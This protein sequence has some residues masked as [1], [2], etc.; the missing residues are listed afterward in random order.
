MAMLRPIWGSSRRGIYGSEFASRPRVHR[1]ELKSPPARRV[2]GSFAVR[3]RFR[4]RRS[5]GLIWGADLSSRRTRTYV[6]ICCFFAKGHMCRRVGPC[7][8]SG[9]A[10][11]D[12]ARRVRLREPGGS[13]LGSR[14]VRRAAAWSRGRSC[15]CAPCPRRRRGAH[16]SFE[17]NCQSRRLGA[18]SRQLR[19]VPLP[20]LLRRW[21]SG[22]GSAA[23][24]RESGSPRR[25]DR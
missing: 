7:E 2:A 14:R 24:V 10:G 9:A 6:R 25:G 5:R 8:S 15:R 17:D 13:G 19:P 3:L 16:L 11:D 22:S 20:A 1:G 12:R 18:P 21:R 4:R 23:A